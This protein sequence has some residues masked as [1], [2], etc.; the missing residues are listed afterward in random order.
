LQFVTKLFGWH[1]KVETY[2]KNKYS[3]IVP[4]PVVSFLLGHCE[5]QIDL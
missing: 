1:N 2:V 5:T 3:M 4:I